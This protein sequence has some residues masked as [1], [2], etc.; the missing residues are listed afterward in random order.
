M[1]AASATGVKKHVSM[2]AVIQ[3]PAL[4]PNHDSI[5]INARQYDERGGLIDTEG[6][7]WFSCIDPLYYHSERC[8]KG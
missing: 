7:H 5:T 6:F 3:S 4:L 2:L 8:A 1:R